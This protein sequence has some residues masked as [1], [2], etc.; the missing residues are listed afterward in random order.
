MKVVLT[1]GGTGGHIYPAL[2][3]AKNIQSN[4]PRAELL[5]IGT[6]RGL[7]A[8]IVPK[9]GLPM[10]HIDV[11]G[12]KRSLSLYNFKVVKKFFSATKAS[13]KILAEFRPDIVIGTGGYVAGPVVYA[14][15]KMGIPSIIHEQNAIPGLTNKFLARYADTVAISFADS[16]AMFPKARNVLFT[17]NPR[18]SE[19]VAAD[20]NAGK[21]SLDFEEELPTVVVVG[22]S[23]GAKA[24]NQLMEAWLQ[25]KREMPFQ[26]VFVTGSVHYEYFR[27]RTPGK[28]VKI[29]P[30]L[31]N[32]P[33]V[34]ACADLVIGRAGA[35]FLSEI[36]ALGI[37]SILIPS[38]YV[39]NNH[40]LHNARAL[41]AAGAAVVIEEKNITES[42]I[43]EHVLR[44]FQDPIRMSSFKLAAKKMGTP[45][46]ADLFRREIERLIKKRI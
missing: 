6:E 14:A 2:A 7:E 1:G 17:G 18:A 29:Y 27:K 43:Q 25:E 39:T 16:K 42:N 15:R 23:R 37:P 31:Y 34:L 11:S 13:K 36:T 30:F 26:V 33:E 20:A 41:E 22:G 35:T 46:A 12:F 38:P 10:C 5:Y 45:D 19:V 40:Q 28:R 3:L 4:H 44:F 9:S 32:M 24:I 21:L 8:D